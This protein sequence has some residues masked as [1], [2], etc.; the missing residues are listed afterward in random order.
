MLT[1]PSDIH[2]E[3]GVVTQLRAYLA[4][5]DLAEDGRL[6]PERELASALGVSRAELRKALDVL[7]AEGQLWRHV[8][9]GTF[10]GSRPL[11]TFADIAAL[12]RRSNPAEVMRARIAMEPEITRAAA[13]TATPADISEMRLCLARSRQAETWR[14]YEGWD[15]R[16]HRTIA[17]AT[18]N[19]L[20]LGLFDTLNAVR[21]A[22]TWGR[23]RSVPVRPLPS[24]HS[25]AEH[26]AIVDAIE[27][28]DMAG[29]A[30]AMRAHLMTVER[31]LMEKQ[32]RAAGEG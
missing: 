26:E 14:Q 3:K 11:D 32:M 4:Q 27:H 24:H 22:V 6:P 20:L 1:P 23:L 15:T 5:S 17:E 18:Q 10:M 28:R 2:P 13:F 21:R 7:E 25:F 9:K 12:A 29:A 16:L 30:S 31:K 8:G 19:S